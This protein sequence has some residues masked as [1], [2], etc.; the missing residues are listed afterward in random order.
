[1][2]ENLQLGEF[3]YEQPAVG[4]TE[5]IFKHALTQEVSYNSVLIDRRKDLHER[6]GAAMEKLYANSIDD[7][8]D[9]LAHHY[10][11]SNNVAKALEYCE[12]SGRQAVQRSAYTDAMRDLTGALELLMRNA[13][14]PRARPA[15]SCG[16]RITW[17]NSLKHAGKPAVWT[18]LLRQL[19]KLWMLSRSK[20]NV[21]GRPRSVGF[22]A[23][24]CLSKALPS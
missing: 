9:G 5:Y 16:A 3:I 2:L 20:V 22:A 14:K 21:G 7:H 12:R 23:N 10:G 8:L 11:K 13:R 1:M 19:R 24:C 18:R 4:D 6:I 17:R 15:R